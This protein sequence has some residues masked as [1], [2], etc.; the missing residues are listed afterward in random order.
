MS[1]NQVPLAAMRSTLRERLNLVEVR[2]SFGAIGDAQTPSFT[3]FQSPDFGFEL[4]SPITFPIGEN[5]IVSEIV[6]RYDEED[7]STPQVMFTYDL[8]NPESFSQAGDFILDDFKVIFN[9]TT[10]EAV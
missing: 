7:G 9:Q 1:F 5:Q 3:N 4:N 8:E 6:F 10:E 2:G